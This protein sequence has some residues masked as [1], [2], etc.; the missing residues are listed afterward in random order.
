MRNW[1]SYISIALLALLLVGCGPKV[2]P[3]AQMTVEEPSVP[4]TTQ[5][6][7]PP[8]ETEPSTE[9]ETEPQEERFLITL[10]G[11]CTLGCDSGMYY[12]GWG[13]ANVIGEDYDHPF[14]NVREY[15]EKDDLTLINFEG[16]LCDSGRPVANKYFTFRGPT[17]YIGMLT[18]S[19]VEAATLANNHTL[20]YG[21]DGYATT[22]ETFENAGVSYVEKNG[23]L[24]YTTPSGLTVGIYAEDYSCFD[25]D[26]LKTSVAELREQG[27][28]LVIYAVH[29]GK[30]GSYYPQIHQIEQA[31]EVVDAGVDIVYGTHPH[32]LQNIEHYGDGVIFYSLGNFSFGGHAN[33]RDMDS[34]L[35]QQEIIRWPDGTVELGELTLIPI[36][37]SSLP[38]RNNYQPTPYPADHEGY[39]RVF[40]KLEGLW[41]GRDLLVDYG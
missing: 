4:P 11:D 26:L 14:R 19:S 31:R 3:S 40:E 7:T 32:V 10:T 8:T 29:W 30:E 5:E 25:M 24:L 23:T 6:T 21:W 27:A 15:F 2:D 20:D 39:A 13:F 18:G 9:P 41:Q 17:A 22:L 36:C 16:V 35:V 28:E 38:E 1:K 37:I 34:V 12:A 33:P